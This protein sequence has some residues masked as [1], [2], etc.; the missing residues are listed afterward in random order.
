MRNNHL[1]PI[2]VICLLMGGSILS[3]CGHRSG[4]QT[5][6]GKKPARAT[7]TA[8]L[9]HV[10]PSQVDEKG[11]KLWQ[12][13]ASNLQVSEVNQGGE[14]QNVH[15]TLYKEGKPELIVSAPK[16]IAEY[17]DKKLYLTG[18]IKAESIHQ[19]ATFTAEKMTWDAQTHQFVGT[20]SVHLIRGPV[21]ITGG[22]IS[23]DTQFKKV[24]L[25]G[26]PTISVH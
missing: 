6:G 23:G 12:A 10:H 25:Q 14:M 1:W 4:K 13:S 22:Q 7:I 5:P 9:T 11:R 17:K 16:M 24:R 26:N 18:G 15:V 20:G 8:R 19:K 3:G 21:Q 2:L